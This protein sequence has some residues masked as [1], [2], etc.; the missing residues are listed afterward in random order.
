MVMIATSRQD[1]WME[2]S[3]RYKKEKDK[4]KDKD[5]EQISLLSGVWL[6]EGSFCVKEYC[7]RSANVIV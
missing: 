4:D 1:I 7:D 3:F 2:N 6:A 5:K